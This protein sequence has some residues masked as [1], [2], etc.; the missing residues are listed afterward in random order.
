MNIL[1]YAY[2]YH[3]EPIG[4]APLMTELAEGLVQRGHHVR[5]V[6]GMPNYPQRQ[7]YEGYRGKL[8]VTEERNGVKIQR[9]FVWVRPKPGLV[10]RILLETSFVGTSFIQALNGKRPDVILLTVPPLPASVPATVFKWMQRAP[11][12]LNLQDVLPEAAV[13]AGL[14]TNKALIRVFESLERF[15]YRYANQIAAISD[16]FVENLINKGVNPDKI[17][18]IPNWVDTDFIRPL[19]KE[20]NSFRREQGLDGKFIILYSGNIALTQGLETL[21][22]AAAQ[23]LDLPDVAI[24]IVGEDQA[25]GA[26]RDRRDEIGATNVKLLPFQPRERL[27]EMLS[28]ANVGMVMQKKTVIAINMPSKIQVLLAS[29]LPILASV[30][31]AGTAAKAVQT[32]GGGWVVPPEDPE[33]IAQAIRQLKAAP[34]TLEQLSQQGRQYALDN[35]SFSEALD[36]YETL[37]QTVI[38]ES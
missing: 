26:L 9:C 25:L 16:G 7:I 19:D 36:R 2:N 32:S 4:I 1:I 15:S 28:A 38:H 22:Q 34:D 24:V 12:V 30:P 20:N 10:D 5:V 35:Y 6:T 8:Y 18:L 33:A 17:T 13:V 11:V 29:G 37:F 21:I 31:D 14:L 27:P 23:L 3:P